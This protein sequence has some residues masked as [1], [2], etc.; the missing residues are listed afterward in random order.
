ML[1][2]MALA[3]N[4]TVYV[5][6]GIQHDGLI[7]TK[8]VGVALPSWAKMHYL[9]NTYLDLGLRWDHNKENKAGFQ[10]LELVTRA[11]LTQWP[12]LGYDAQFGGHGLSHLHVGANFKWGKITLGDV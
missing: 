12:M 4:D 10:G 1:P 3:S 7:P 11:E 5:V 6:G 2:A 9:S 8:E